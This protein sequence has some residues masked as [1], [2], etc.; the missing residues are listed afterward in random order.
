MIFS[1][2]EKKKKFP[3]WQALSQGMG[4]PRWEH[5][6]FDHYTLHF[7]FCFVT[8]C[9]F[10]KIMFSCFAVFYKVHSHLI[11]KFIS[12]FRGCCLHIPGNPSSEREDLPP[13]CLECEQRRKGGREPELSPPGWSEKRLGGCRR[14]GAWQS[15]SILLVTPPIA[16]QFCKM[17]QVLS[18]HHLKICKSNLSTKRLL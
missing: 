16:Q 4:A 1:E 18:R 9:L 8:F 14:R 5:F 15:L 2:T 3:Y 13:D 11:K 7:S 10:P 12:I 6:C 17:V